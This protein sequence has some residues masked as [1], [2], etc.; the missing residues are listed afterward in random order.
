[1]KLHLNTVVSSQDLL[2][3]GYSSVVVASGVVPRSIKLPNHSSV[4]P[5]T[6]KHKV[7]VLSYIDVLRDGAGNSV[8]AQY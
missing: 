7:S 8:L 1:M 3:K 4:D 6:G 2:D 5:A